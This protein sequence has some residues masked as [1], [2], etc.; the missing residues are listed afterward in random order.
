MCR[1]VKSRDL[2][3]VENTLTDDQQRQ[4]AS[5]IEQIR[6][7]WLVM[8]G[9]YSRLFWAFPRFNVPQGTIIS[10]SNPSQLLV[11]MDS[12][13]AEQSAVSRESVYAAPV[14]AS[15]LPRRRSRWRVG[16]DSPT[17]TEPGMGWTSQA[18][19]QS[20]GR[21]YEPYPPDRDSH[22]AD[23]RY[24]EPYEADRSDL[25]PYDYLEDPYDQ[26]PYASSQ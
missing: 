3:E 23:P 15:A 2:S 13:E 21:S 4:I 14:R 11:S 18:M 20:A 8:W 6:P 17:D 10:A 1:E 5:E 26:D 24:P 25:D 9:C 12:V 16:A 22:D 19:P 7:S